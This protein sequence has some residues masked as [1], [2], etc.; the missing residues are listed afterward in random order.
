MQGVSPRVGDRKIIIT[1]SDGV[2]EQEGEGARVLS[3]P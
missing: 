3:F 1:S 2:L